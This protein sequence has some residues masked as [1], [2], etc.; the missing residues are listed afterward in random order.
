MQRALTPLAIL[1]TLALLAC[2]DKSALEDE[3]NANRE[4]AAYFDDCVAGCV[5]DRGLTEEECERACEDSADGN[6]AAEAEAAY[7]DCIDEGGSE[8]ECSGRAGEMYDAC[9]GDRTETGT[10]PCDAVAEQAWQDCIDAG[11]TDEDCR[12]AA[13]VAYDACTNGTGT[14]R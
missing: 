13:G 14:T 3:A 11:G 9:T 10:D 7:V 12:E 2:A 1:T 5:G 8:D 6:C 4:P